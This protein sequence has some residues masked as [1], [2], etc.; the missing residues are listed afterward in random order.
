M[1]TG[2]LPA[3]GFLVIFP[4]LAWFLL[5]DSSPPPR[6]GVTRENFQRIRKGM[7]LGKVEA[8][9]G[10]KGH[11]VRIGIRSPPIGKLWKGERF[12]VL[13]Y[14]HNGAVDG[15]YLQDLAYARN[16]ERGITDMAEE[17]EGAGRWL[18]RLRPW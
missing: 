3:T 16:D 11:D 17:D 10:G 18:R 2:R 1:P 4:A 12:I 6:P 13:V 15:G 8:L 7:P 5:A 14:I 9:M